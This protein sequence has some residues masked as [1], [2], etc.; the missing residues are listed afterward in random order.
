MSLLAIHSLRILRASPHLERC[1]AECE[2]EMPVLRN[3]RARIV[4][5]VICTD[6]QQGVFE[7]AEILGSPQHCLVRGGLCADWKSIQ[8]RHRGHLINLRDLAYWNRIV[9]L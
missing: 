3:V 9:R 8:N 5:V 2:C 7:N 4:F 1:V 6:L